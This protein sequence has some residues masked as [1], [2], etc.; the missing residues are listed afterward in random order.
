MR[1][2]NKDQ[3]QMLQVDD[4]EL[5]KQMAEM[6]ARMEAEQAAR[7]KEIDEANRK[8]EEDKRR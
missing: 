6:K 4:K 2:A 3:M 1:E 8:M 5:E 7:Q